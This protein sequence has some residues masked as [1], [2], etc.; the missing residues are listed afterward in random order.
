MHW[1]AWPLRVNAL[2]SK[3]L[4]RHFR[5]L[6]PAYTMRCLPVGIDGGSVGDYIDDVELGSVVVIDN[7]GRLD[8]TI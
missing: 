3:S 2:A 5:L 8:A 1:I 6:G 7:A 4:D